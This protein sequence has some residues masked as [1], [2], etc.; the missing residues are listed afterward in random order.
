MTDIDIDGHRYRIELSPG[1]FNDGEYV[2]YDRQTHTVVVSHD[3]AP[4]RRMSLVAGLLLTESQRI[5][6]Q[7]AAA[8]LMAV[9]VDEALRDALGTPRRR[10][11]QAYKL[12]TTPMELDTHFGVSPE[13]ATSRVVGPGDEGLIVRM[14]GGVPVPALASWGCDD[15]SAAVTTNPDDEFWSLN[16]QTGRCMVPATGWFDLEPR[17]PVMHLLSSAKLFAFAGVWGRVN[18]PG[19]E[20]RLVFTVLTTEPGN[21]DAGGTDPMP[22]V[23]APD[24]YCPWLDPATDVPALIDQVRRPWPKNDLIHMALG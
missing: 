21:A 9:E 19:G 11:S 8:G 16:V 17:K 24:E 18:A 22:V 7:R 23:L 13:F 3:L 20:K 14:D 15:Q 5:A 4:H 1:P 12:T 10:G 2:R 6:Y